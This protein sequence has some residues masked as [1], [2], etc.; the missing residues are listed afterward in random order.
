MGDDDRIV[1]RNDMESRKDFDRGIWEGDCW[2]AVMGYSKPWPAAPWIT[3]GSFGSDW[4]MSAGLTVKNNWSNIHTVL[5][6][7]CNIFDLLLSH[8]INF[9]MLTEIKLQCYQKNK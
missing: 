4:W 6:S 1:I 8:L 5:S 7:L 9:H 2:I 3:N